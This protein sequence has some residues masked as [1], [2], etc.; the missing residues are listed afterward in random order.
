MVHRR[1]AAILAAVG[2][3]LALVTVGALK[4]HPGRGSAWA[5]AEYGAFSGAENFYTF[6]APSAGMEIRPTFEV[7]ERDGRVIHD[8]LK[9]PENDEVDLRVSDLAGLF[10]W[11][12]EDLHRLLLASWA[13]L[14]FTRHPG[15]QRV[16]VRVDGCDVPSMEEYRR[17]ERLSWE[18][19][20]TAAFSPPAAGGVAGD[21]GR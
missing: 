11:W 2:A 7:T 15:A 16:V 20:E 10:W 13:G 5:I 17:G 3:H 9:S 6:F 18:I 4:L 14:M 21:A 1:R 19:L 8:V 12:D